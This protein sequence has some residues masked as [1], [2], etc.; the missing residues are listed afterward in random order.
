MVLSGLGISTCL[1]HSRSHIAPFSPLAHTSPIPTMP[2]YSR[3]TLSQ[4]RNTTRF[5]VIFDTHFP[6]TPHINCISEWWGSRLRML[7]SLA[8]ARRG[9]NKET[10]LVT[11][12]F[13]FAP[14]CFMRA[15]S[16]SQH[17]Q[18]GGE[19]AELDCKMPA[20]ASQLAPCKWLQSATWR[21]RNALSVRLTL[22]DMQAILGRGSPLGTPHALRRLRAIRENYDLGIDSLS[23]TCW[24]M[25]SFPM[26]SIKAHFGLSTEMPWMQS[27][28]GWNLA[29]FSVS[30]LLH[31]R[32]CLLPCPA[33]VALSLVHLFVSHGL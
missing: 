14:S 32:E 28:L 27:L 31:F 4:F 11:P 20:C 8:G 30:S 29:E 18:F 10:L 15:Q 9:Q 7:K 17:V 21:V 24:L 2:P 1:S 23:D 5:S 13:S 26:T 3:I 12:V 19:E 6:F 25:V 33:R 16:C 22:I